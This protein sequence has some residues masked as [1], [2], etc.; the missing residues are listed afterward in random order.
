M[1]FDELVA[2]ADAISS[3]PQ[4]AHTVDGITERVR[5]EELPEAEFNGLPFGAIQLDEEGRILRY[6]D[7]ES[8]LSGVEQD[9]AIGKHFFTELAP[10]T[11]VKEFHG[12]FKAGVARKN[13]NEQFRY[14]FS[15]KRNPIDVTVT[16]FY[17]ELTKSIWVFVR[18]V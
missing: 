6:N 8:Q 13:L 4:E 18:P 1:R 5:V 3:Q 15:F 11:D 10:C 2:Q 9:S 16:L 17:S 7:Y 12:R 14:H